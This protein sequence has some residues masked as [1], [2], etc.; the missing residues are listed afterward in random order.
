MFRSFKSKFVNFMRFPVIFDAY[1]PYD[2]IYKRAFAGAFLS[3][4]NQ[5]SYRRLDF[6][7][8]PAPVRSKVDG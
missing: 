2:A 3:D 5:N 8:P 7:K 1:K 6:D 4:V